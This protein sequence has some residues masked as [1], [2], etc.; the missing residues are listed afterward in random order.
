MT[1]EELKVLITAQTTKLNTEIDKVKKQLTG[2]ETKSKQTS[3]TI[4]KAF[5][6]VKFSVIVAG[7]IKVGKAAVDAAS[8]LAEVQ[9]VVETTFGAATDRVNKFAKT[10]ITQFGLSEYS[11][12]S[13]ASS[14]MAMSNGMGVA[15]AAGA[16]MAITLAGLSGDLASF[17]NTN[18]DQAKT[19]LKGIYTGETEALKNYGV[20]MTETTLSAYALSQGITK[21]Y[22]AMTQ[23]EKVQLRYMF[24]LESTA[25]AQG[26]FAKTSGSWANQTKILTEQWKQFISIIGAGLIKALTP[27]IKALN[28]LLSAAINVANGVSEAFSRIFGI[29][30]QTISVDTTKAT[31]NVEETTEAVDKMKKELQLANFDEI[32]QLKSA[33]SNEDSSGES[34]LPDGSNIL[35]T[36]TEQVDNS[37]ITGLEEQSTRLDEIM[38]AIADKISEWKEKLPKIDIQFDKENLLNGLTDLALAFVNAFANILGSAATFGINLANS[39]NFDAVVNNL[40]TAG[41]N[42]ISAFETIV[43]TII[44]LANRI[45]EDINLGLLIEK[46]TQV[47]AS[48]SNFVNQLVQAVAPA[49]IAFYETGLS[50]I[51]QWIG[52]KLAD[53]LSFVSALLDDWAMWFQE[54]A[55]GISDFATK[56]GELVAQIWA[57]IEPL[58]DAAWEVFKEILTTISELFQT[59]FT[60]ILDNAELVIAAIT[61]IVTAF[62]AYKAALGITKLIEAFRNGTLLATLAV[63]A[64]SAAMAISN[65]VMMANPIAIVVGLIAGLVAAFVVLWNNCEGFRQ[66]WIDLW[67]GICDAIQTAWDFICGIV[68]GIVSAVK[69]AINAVKEFFGLGSGSSEANVSKSINSRGVQTY[70]AVPAAIPA[71]ASGGALYSPTVAQMAEYPGASSNPEIVAPQSI[72]RETMEEANAGVI[73]AVMAIGSQITNAVESKDTNIYMD[74]TKVTRKVMATEKT[75]NKYKGKPL[76]N[77]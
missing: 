43:V 63:K 59:F 47:I 55:Q 4:Q 38:Q 33:S 77:T 71:L 52:V 35:K 41:V 62:I 32:N 13:A 70:S 14:F 22:S 26:D 60:W 2:L 21:Q 23:A 1:I 9:N 76:I 11:A 7:L 15:Q 30:K 74:S 58:L 3:N 73:S 42:M 6:A 36:E 17:W 28:E 39:I 57:L 29:D 61:G 25:Q 19:A 46:V 68:D 27:A 64:Y 37:L 50:P 51:V 49:C 24:V 69:D 12:K 16:D 45:A 34:N 53:A 40:T 56:I 72:M 66:F 31:E 20:V 65:A 5:N 8:D 54:N 67:N 18:A 10:A 48:F 75:L 44:T